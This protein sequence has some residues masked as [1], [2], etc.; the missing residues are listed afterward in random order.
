MFSTSRNHVVCPTSAT[1]ASDN[2]HRLATA[3]T[4][5]PKRSTRVSQ[6]SLVPAR[7]SA[8]TRMRSSSSADDL[9]VVCGITVSATWLIPTEIPPEPSVGREW[10]LS[11]ALLQSPTRFVTSMVPKKRG[12]VIPFFGER[13]LPSWALP[14]SA[15]RPQPTAADGGRR[16]ADANG[17][18]RH[19]MTARGLIEAA[20][21]PALSQLQWSGP[22]PSKKAVD[23]VVAGNA[24]VAGASRTRHR[25][26][27]GV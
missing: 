16:T 15:S 6:A 25:G 19:G 8:T 7:A 27:Y 21:R 1:S 14:S 3:A 2:L 4:R 12:P 23:S 9:S 22:H 5:P 17:S 13:P 11:T 20:L 26:A 10:Q 24:R 18:R